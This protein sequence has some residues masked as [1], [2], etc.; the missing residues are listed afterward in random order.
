[1]N[2]L[3]GNRQLGKIIDIF[4]GEE[5][6]G[7]LT[8]IVYIQFSKNGSQQGFGALAFKSDLHANDF[9]QDLCNLFEVEKL[10]QLKDKECYA[11][12]CFGERDYIEGLENPKTGKKFLI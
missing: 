7:I 6:H 12:R 1:M 8:C 2:N 9:V 5:D 10:H 11:L 3:N 4:F